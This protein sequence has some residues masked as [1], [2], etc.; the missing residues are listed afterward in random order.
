MRFGFEWHKYGCLVFWDEDFSWFGEFGC[1]GFGV[2]WKYDWCKGGSSGGSEGGC[3]SGLSGGGGGIR[4]SDGACVVMVNGTEMNTGEGGVQSG[5][6]SSG[7]VGG[8]VDRVLLQVP[9]GVR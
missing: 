2:F 4:G 6:S 7:V 5:R 8:G 3:G 1:F 9:E